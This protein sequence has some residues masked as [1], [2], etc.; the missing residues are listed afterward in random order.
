MAVSAY[1]AVIDALIAGAIAAL[2]NVRV[3]DG[4]EVTEDPGDFL[5]IG[6]N[7]TDDTGDVNAGEF[8]QA[9]A[10]ANHTARDEEGEINCL[11]LSWNG[12]GNQKAARDAAF[13]T[14]EAVAAMCRTNPSL[15][16]ASL[17]WTSFGT[18][19][20]PWQNHDENGAMC[21]VEFQIAFRARI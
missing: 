15:G 16:V 6:S 14:C 1:P 18:R 5:M 4:D 3:Y 13:A 10:N 11:S 21:L 2:P 17:L 7:N 9:W 20:T 12:D 19:G 8:R